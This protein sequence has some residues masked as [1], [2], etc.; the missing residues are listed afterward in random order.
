[1]TYILPGQCS[2]DALQYEQP[3][4]NLLPMNIF[5]ISFLL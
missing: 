2:P 4:F 3:Q 1:M 5:D